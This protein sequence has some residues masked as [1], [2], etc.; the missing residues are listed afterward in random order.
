MIKIPKLP[1]HDK[2]VVKVDAAK[3]AVQKA[4][5]MIT[6]IFILFANA[7]IQTRT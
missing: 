4:V 2:T 5:F 6:D 1:F 7:F 3:Q